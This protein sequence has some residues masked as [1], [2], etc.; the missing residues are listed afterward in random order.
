MA[1]FEQEVLKWL[2]QIKL[3]WLSS[4]IFE[5]DNLYSLNAEGQ[6]NL[7]IISSEKIKWYIDKIVYWMTKI[8]SDITVNSIFNEIISNLII[9]KEFEEYVRFLIVKKFDENKEDAETIQI[10]YHPYMF[11]FTH[12]PR[13]II[14][15]DNKNFQLS[16]DKILECLRIFDAELEKCEAE[17]KSKQNNKDITWEV[18]TQRICYSKKPVEI[19]FG[20]TEGF[21][22]V[23]SW[24]HYEKHSAK[25]TKTL[26]EEDFNEF[27]ILKIR[28]RFGTHSYGKKYH[29]KIFKRTGDEY[30]RNLRR[31]SDCLDLYCVDGSMFYV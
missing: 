12:S 6:Y 21:A 20:H 22:C 13:L 25:T 8:N 1:S 24:K 27:R 19:N 4:G 29:N 7:S 14:T 30:A 23:L 10:I 26:T 11:S 9:E 15:V 5:D 31:I 2:F 28:H 17:Y 16:K 3:S 18:C